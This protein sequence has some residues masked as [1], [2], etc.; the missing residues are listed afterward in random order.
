ME[1]V[2]L[3]DPPWKGFLGFLS[4]PLCDV[5]LT[6]EASISLPVA[7]LVETLGARWK[8]SPRPHPEYPLSE[9]RMRPDYAV[10]KSGRITGFLELKAPGH[11]VTPDGFTK[12]TGSRG[13]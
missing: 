10:E 7:K 6:T 12:G 1:R 2:A 11:D 5:L 13:S 3:L 8:L 9:A 4:V